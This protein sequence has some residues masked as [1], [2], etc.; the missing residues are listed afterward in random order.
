MDCRLCSTTADGGPDYSGAVSDRRG[1]GFDFALVDGAR[2]DLAMEVVLALVK[3][4]GYVFLDNTDLPNDDC[5]MAEAR[6]I[7]AAARVWRF[8]DL[9]PGI[10]M[11]N[12][13][14]LAQLAEA[15]ASR[16]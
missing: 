9:S 1:S 11:V 14:T 4:G 12:E 16:P 10:V 5:R 7:E 13:G 2:R 15:P 8:N 3:P 6:L